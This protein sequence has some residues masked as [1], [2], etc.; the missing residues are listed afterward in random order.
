MYQTPLHVEK[1]FFHYHLKV[2]GQ[3]EFFFFLK[4][5]NTFILQGRVKL[6]KS[7][8]KGMHN[9]TKYFN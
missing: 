4:E 8:S 6:I 1:L 2:C 5:I 3:F 7:V 9:V